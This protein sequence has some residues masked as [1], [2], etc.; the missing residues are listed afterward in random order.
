M[1]F[2]SYQSMAAIATTPHAVLILQPFCQASNTILY[3]P[4]SLGHLENVQIYQGSLKE[5]LA[6]IWRDYQAFVLVLATG[7]VTRLIAPLLHDKSTDPAILVVDENGKFV[8]SLCGGHQG[9]GDALTRLVAEFLGATPIITGVS[10]SLNLP[11]IDILGLPFGWKKGRGDWTGVSAAI[12]KQYPVEVIQ[13]AGSTLWQNALPPNHPFHFQD[14]TTPKGRVWIGFTQ[15]TF[16]PESEFP[17][18]QWHPRVLWVGLGCER[19]TPKALIDRGIRQVFQRNHLAEAAIAGIATIDIKADEV[20]ILELCR[21]RDLPLHTFSAEELKQVNVPNPS[22][23]VHR[24]VGTPSVAEA[25]CQLSITNYQLPITNYQLSSLLV[26]KQVYKEEGVKGAVTIAVAVSESEYT[27]RR[28]KLFLVGTGPGALEQMT[29]A[30]RSAVTEADVIIGY[31]LYLDLIAPLQ[32]PGQIVESFPITRERDRAQRA[33]ALAQWGLTVAVVSSGDCGIYGMAGLV[34]EALEQG[35]WDGKTPQVQVF[36]GITALQAA[37]SRVGSPLMH[38]FCAISLSD[39]LT[40]WDVIVKRLQGAAMGDFV[41]ALYNP[42]SR[43]RQEQIVQAQQIFLQYRQGNTPVALV[44]SAYR[45]EEEI[46]LTTL[47]QMLQFPIDML[48]TVIIGNCSTYQHENWL[49][50]P[51]GYLSGRMKDEG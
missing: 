25:A 14:E 26:R 10:A 38:D 39:L 40:P 19:G 50:T 1:L 5:H 7:A 33:I 8:I 27:G 3:V 37:A 44:K 49:I 46:Q 20:G 15:R 36:P 43:Q 9:G 48:T 31:S 2:E 42:R 45:P 22:P 32:R 29:H 6:A 28:G 41:T 18:V 17:K 23:V 12:A 35:G 4:P 11:G 16:E 30:A 51:R 47:E 24:E 21:D 34:M 13:E